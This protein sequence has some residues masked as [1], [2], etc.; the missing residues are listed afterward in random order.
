LVNVTKKPTFVVEDVGKIHTMP[1]SDS[2]LHV[3]SEDL[4]GSA[5]TIGRTK[6]SMA[7]G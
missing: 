6:R 7:I 3:D 1:E 5:A 2:A 4:R